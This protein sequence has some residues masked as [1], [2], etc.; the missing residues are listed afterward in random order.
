MSIVSRILG[1]ERP[2]DDITPGAS[3]AP[4]R[5]PGQYA[6]TDVCV[7]LRLPAENPNLLQAYPHPVDEYGIPVRR[8]S[9]LILGASRTEHER[10]RRTAA[11]ADALSFEAAVAENLLLLRPDDT[12]AAA[13]LDL[14]NAALPTVA[15][16]PVLPLAVT[17]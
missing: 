4:D 17:R 10:L 6:R 9:C 15:D 7:P 13:Y 2:T 5:T 8:P 1:R 14:L 16:R 12:N 11:L 3:P